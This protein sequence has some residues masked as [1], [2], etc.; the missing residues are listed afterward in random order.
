MYPQFLEY[1]NI[2]VS[3]YFKI[4]LKNRGKEDY[5]GINAINKKS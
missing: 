3:L 5:S 4:N 1:I 2:Q